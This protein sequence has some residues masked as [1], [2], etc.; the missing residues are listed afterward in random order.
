MRY[1]SL[2]LCAKIVFAIPFNK[3]KKINI[4]VAMATA[5]EIGMFSLCHFYGM[6]MMYLHGGLQGESFV[7]VIFQFLL[8]I[9]LWLIH[10]N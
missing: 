1:V 6:A 5:M 2:D 4:I 10:Y 8:K 9:S 7:S 3:S